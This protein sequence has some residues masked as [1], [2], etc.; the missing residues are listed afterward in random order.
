MSTTKLTAVLTVAM[1][2]SRS[3]VAASAE[4]E[5]VEMFDHV[6]IEARAIA[7]VAPNF[8]SQLPFGADVR[9]VFQWPRVG[10]TLGARV[11]GAGT[12]AYNEPKDTLPKAVSSIGFDGGLRVFLSATS[13]F[14]PFAAAGLHYAQ[15]STDA[16]DYA[17]LTAGYGEIGVEFPRSSGPRLAAALRCDVG[18]MSKASYS[19]IPVP[20][21]F[22]M[23]SLQVGF[24][25]GGAGTGVPEGGDFSAIPTPIPTPAPPAR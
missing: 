6:G 15:A 25:F 20:D 8:G 18:G 22:V 4:Q 5:V 2:F 11:L 21:A 23:P 12:G 1:S 16:F 14:G 3:A 7:G 17:M 24:L 10:L 9:L 19:R 13:D